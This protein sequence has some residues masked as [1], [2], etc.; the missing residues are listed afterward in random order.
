MSSLKFNHTDLKLFSNTDSEKAKSLHLIN[1]VYYS[2]KHCILIGQQT[3][4]GA[5]RIFKYD[6]VK[7]LYSK[8]MIFRPNYSNID[9]DPLIYFNY[10]WIIIQNE[11]FI[12][13]DY[14]SKLKSEQILYSINL[15]KKKTIKRKSNISVSS[16][17][18]YFEFCDMIHIP[19]TN[20]FIRNNY[21]FS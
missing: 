6:L 18:Y 2:N 13:F 8:F 19:Q 1:M 15:L 4:H 7:Q 12:L 3:G 10:S 11:L 16:Q 21:T 5:I 9:N 17:K 20:K 14:R